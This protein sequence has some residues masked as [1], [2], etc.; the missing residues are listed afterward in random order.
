M[1]RRSTWPTLPAR[2][3][4]G[5]R[6]SGG[7]PRRPASHHDES[8]ATSRAALFLFSS[9]TEAPRPRALLLIP[10]AGTEPDLPRLLSCVP[11][12]LA[13]EWEL[14]CLVMGEGRA[15]GPLPP[16]VTRLTRAAGWGHGD[17]LKVGMHFAIERGFAAVAVLGSNPEVQ[18]VH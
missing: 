12:Q 18:A 10:D 5:S 7:G 8:G 16:A 2:S 15:G 3:G 17:T 11:T 1:A 13:A 6:D 4:S 14:E 9:M